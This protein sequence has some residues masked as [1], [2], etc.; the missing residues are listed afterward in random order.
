M[1]EIRTRSSIYKLRDDGII[2]QTTLAGVAQTL[3]DAKEN[4]A[5][6]NKLADGQPRPLLVD[7][8]A[9]HSMGPGVR[10]MYSSPEAMRFTSAIAVLTNTSGA[11]RVIAN[12]FISLGAPK[13]P[14]R[15]FGQEAEA[16]AWLLKISRAMQRS[17]G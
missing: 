8:R 7:T 15:L 5:S 6:F 11:G 16:I 10:E 13:A 14:T 3:D 4:I 1:T 9:I 12:L 17:G 2:V